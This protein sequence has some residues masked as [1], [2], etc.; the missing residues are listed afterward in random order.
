MGCAG[1][2]WDGLLVF[3]C[4]GDGRGAE[5]D[6]FYDELFSLNDAGWGEEGENGEAVLFRMQVLRSG[7]ILTEV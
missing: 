6:G 5:D 4:L 7:Q 2:G 3:L 1:M